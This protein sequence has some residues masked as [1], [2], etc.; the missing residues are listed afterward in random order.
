MFVARFWLVVFC[1]LAFLKPVLAFGLQFGVPKVFY[2]ALFFDFVWL[3]LC[4]QL[5]AIPGD[6]CE[7]NE[8]YATDY[9]P[10]RRR[11]QAVLIHFCVQFIKTFFVL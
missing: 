10:F 4:C 7:V 1:L 9:L 11:V 8:S 3:V 5:F 6:T 2:K